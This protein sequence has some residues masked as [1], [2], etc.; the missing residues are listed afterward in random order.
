MLQEARARQVV[1]CAGSINTPQ[2]LMLSGIGA[3]EELRGHGIPVVVD[4]PK[5]GKNLREH[6]LIKLTYRM[7]CLTCNPT[8]GYWQ[9]AKFL[10]QYLLHGQGPLATVFE[11]TGFLKTT[12][13]S[14][15]PDIQ[16]H[17]M[18]VG[19]ANAA[20]EGPIVLPYPAVSILLNKSH[21]LS[22][23]E[24]RLKDSDPRSAPLIR[25]RLLSD[26]RDVATLVKG[27]QL[28][29][30]IMHTRPIDAMVDREE[31][32]GK[33]LRDPPALEE[34]VRG[35]TELGF[36]PAGTCR[37]GTDGDAV[38]TPELRVRG[39]D[40]LWIADA[41]IM[42]DLISGNTNAVCMMI[43]EKLGRAL[44]SNQH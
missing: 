4:L 17:F 31:R 33:D 24:I 19:V 5:V 2:L 38:V 23:G 36:H 32:P 20:D 34:Y 8:A 39:V 28:V 13:D 27:L 35:N 14:S 1:L 40:N 30:R 43:G 3:A 26:E 22:A 25:C 44:V 18:P 15:D 11:A 7:R 12:A 6:P 16:L 41:S 9:K 37:M 29:R 10:Q 42:P 21:P